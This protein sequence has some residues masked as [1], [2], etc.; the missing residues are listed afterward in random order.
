[1]GLRET[2]ARMLLGVDSADLQEQAR[3]A[4]M[5]SLQAD[6]FSERI[7]E[8]E[9]DLEGWQLIS[10]MD[11][12][13]FS[14]PALNALVRRSR[15]MYLSNP[16]VNRAV[17]VQAYYVWGQGVT[18]NA[19]HPDLNAVVQAFLDDPDNLA[20]FTS[21]QA[22]TEKEIDLQLDGN[23]FFVLFPNRATGEVKVRTIPVE[24]IT[25]IVRN[26]QDRKDPWYYK[27]EWMEEQFDEA[28]G[29]IERKPR[30]VYYPDWR[31][32]PPV[33]RR[34]S[35]INNQEVAWDSP[36]CHRRVGG[37]SNMAFGVPEVYCAL[38]WASA[39]V[40]ALEDDATRSRA[41]ARFAYHLTTPPRAGVAAAAKVRLGTGIT[42]A[43]P[44]ET[45]PPPVAGATFVS[46]D[47]L[48]LDP[49]RLSGANL[50]TDHSRPLRLMVAAGTGTPDTIL[51]GDAD[52]G[53]LATAKTLD[54]PTELKMRDRQ[55]FWADFY[56]DL[57]DYVI[58]QAVLAPDGRLRSFGSLMRDDRGQDVIVMDDDPETGEPIDRHLDVNFPDLLERDVAARVRAVVD[59]LTASGHPSLP[60]WPPKL[61]ARLLLTALGVD[62]LDEELKALFPN[63]G[64]GETPGMGGMMPEDDGV[65]EALR[66]V[67]RVMAER[68]RNG[69]H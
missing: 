39:Y 27:R 21:Q 29:M 50:P 18:I 57:L 24:E 35:R 5:A 33:G 58:D 60:F 40:A 15:L 43:A 64:D 17:T 31:Y 53:N 67:A 42:N 38:D 16:L 22:R 66:E 1:M 59:A 36:I 23:L 55:S 61:Q 52:V 41:L 14:K 8:L 47:N 49:V 7:A 65:A 37:L 46:T 11:P 13:E 6:L 9:Q 48:N 19:K 12:G 10:G 51:S 34:P 62:D 32:H 68:S 25:E 20:E 4:Q 63:E 3:I 26:P 54:R 28:R 69:V 44:R 2:A 45:N 56:S 30:V